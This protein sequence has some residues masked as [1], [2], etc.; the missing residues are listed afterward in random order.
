MIQYK[1]IAQLVDLD[2]RLASIESPEPERIVELFRRL[3]AAT[4]RAI[5]IWR[6]ESGLF[7]LG[8]EQISIPRT[9]QPNDVLTY[10]AASKH[11]GAYVLTDFA[12][13]FEDNK[14]LTEKVESL[15]SP[16]NPVHRQLIMLSNFNALP[17]SLDVQSVKIRH[18]MKQRA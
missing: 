11:Y 8:A 10:I 17:I 2:Y 5:Y 18:S 13:Y 15:I 3:N 1:S 4:G 14:P 12:D 7:R 6:Y 16:D 9:G